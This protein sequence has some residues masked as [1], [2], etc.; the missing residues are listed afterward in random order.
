MFV[1]TYE[2]AAAFLHDTQELLEQQEAANNLM[3]GI[4]LHLAQGGSY[5]D[6]PPYL[7][8][9]QDEEGIAVAAVMTPP[10]NLVVYSPRQRYGAAPELVLRDLLGRGLA[11]P[12]VLGPRAIAAAFA[13]AWP[14]VSG[15]VAELAM[16]Q[17]GYELRQVIHPRYSPGRMRPAEAGDLD[18]LTEWID[19]F[20][21]EVF[22]GRQQVDARAA[23]E[24]MLAR[25][26]LFLWD[27]GRPSALANRT[28]PLRHSISVGLV[29]TPPE[30][31][32]RGYAS[33]L[34]ATLSQHLLDSGY[35]FCTL[36]TDLANP[37][38]NAI[39]QRIGYRAI[40][41][42]DEYVLAGDG[43]REA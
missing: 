31:R 12:G 4:T 14:G 16:R 43:K 26:D 11:I 23:A 10:H 20:H 3:L 33:S 21:F 24:R 19:A 13:E 2:N 1:A 37:T 36:F 18:L 32:G 39:Y 8:T 15:G 9:V 30:L 17:R 28:R 34:V 41:D 29:Y 35:E 38:S 5:G 42:Y 6:L 40:G 27:D 25:Q 7:A 22:A